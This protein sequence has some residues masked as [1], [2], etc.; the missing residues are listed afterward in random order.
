MATLLYRL[1]R[2]SYRRAR[3][4]IVAWGRLLAAA[5]GAGIGLGGQTDE[6]F[7]IPG[8]ESQVALDQLNALFPAVAGAS[9]QAVVVA[10]EGASVTDDDVRAEI[11][12][13]VD[14]LRH[15]REDLAPRLGRADGLQWRA[16]QF[17]PKVQLAAV[18]GVDDRA[19]AALANQ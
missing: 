5:L 1:G 13:L 7:S 18:A 17:E 11:A 9:A 15:A 12:V 8:T 14:E 4:V 16:R 2:F 10:P 6:T 19:I 3:L